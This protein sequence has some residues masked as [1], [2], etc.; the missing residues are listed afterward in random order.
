MRILQ[1]RNLCEVHCSY[2]YWWISNEE[3][4]CAN[5]TICDSRIPS[6]TYC[7]C[8]KSN[9]ANILHFRSRPQTVAVN[10]G[11]GHI[12][13]NPQG[14][15]YKW[16]YVCTYR[17]IMY[18]PGLHTTCTEIICTCATLVGTC[19]QRTWVWVG[20]VHKGHRCGWDLYT[21]DMGMGGTCTQKTW[22]WVGPVHKGQRCGWDLYTKDMGVGGTCTQRT[23]VWVGPV[24]KGH[25]CGWDLYTKDMGVGGT[26][27]QRTW[28]WVG[29][30]HKG[31]GS[32][33]TLHVAI[34]SLN[35]TQ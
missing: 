25:G 28:V 15:I 17:N 24:H 20:P 7:F 11:Y 30:V 22:V 21:K 5:I 13:V 6:L 31:H 10:W 29:P 12:R 32:L 33:L 19:T 3:K 27:T 2:Y 1:P 4:Y 14:P 18:M 16:I 34:A 8:Q 35:G 26:C 23:R 9:P